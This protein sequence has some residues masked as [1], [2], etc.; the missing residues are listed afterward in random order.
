MVSVVVV[1]IPK[2]RD[3]GEDFG[4]DPVDWCSLVPPEPNQ[5]E[6]LESAL[7][8]NVKL[9]MQQPLAVIPMC[10]LFV[11]LTS[12]TSRVVVVLPTQISVL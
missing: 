3:D 4:R 9:N 7:L 8:E 2:V 10:D 6:D 11:R 1:L 5:V 12:A